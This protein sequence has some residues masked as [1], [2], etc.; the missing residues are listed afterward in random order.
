MKYKAR[1]FLSGGYCNRFWKEYF[2]VILLR[3]RCAAYTRCTPDTGEV[4]LVVGAGARW[5]G[6]RP[7]AEHDAGADDEDCA[8]PGQEAPLGSRLPSHAS[9]YGGSVA[10]TG[11]RLAHP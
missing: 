5:R 2:A 3:A 1:F 7:C 4:E 6:E 10:Q 9:H 8:V 11:S